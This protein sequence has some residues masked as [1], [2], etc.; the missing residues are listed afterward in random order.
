MNITRIFLLLYWLQ[1]VNCILQILKSSVYF[2][3]CCIGI[4][5]D[6][7]GCGQSILEYLPCLCRIVRGMITGILIDQILQRI[8]I[9]LLRCFHLY[10]SIDR[11]LQ[12]IIGL[13]DLQLCRI[14]ICNDFLRRSQLLLQCCPAV[15]RVRTLIQ[16]FRLID[17]CIQCILIGN[18]TQS[19]ELFDIGPARANLQL[20]KP[21][22]RC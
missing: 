13:R 15:R 21:P 4:C 14:G 3:L 17:G 9:C 6:S 2:C 18:Q 7:P 10:Q 8:F 20:T 19:A 1:S 22:S 11:S 16:T 5:I 12:R